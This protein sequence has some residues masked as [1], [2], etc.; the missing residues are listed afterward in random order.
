MTTAV[1]VREEYGYDTYIN[2]VSDPTRPQPSEIGKRLAVEGPHPVRHIVHAHMGELASSPLVPQY[3]FLSE[4]E[5]RAVVD[6]TRQYRRS[7]VYRAMMEL[8]LSN[9]GLGA[10]LYEAVA[11]E[12]QRRLREGLMK[13]EVVLETPASKEASREAVFNRACSGTDWVARRELLY[14][15]VLEG[16]LTRTEYDKARPAYSEIASICASVEHRVAERK[17]P[18]SPSLL[19]SAWHGEMYAL[20]KHAHYVYGVI[21]GEVVADND[22]AL[23]HMCSKLTEPRKD[24]AP[25]RAQFEYLRREYVETYLEEMTDAFK[26]FEMSA[27]IIARAPYIGSDLSGEIAYEEWRGLMRTLDEEE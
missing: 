23:M 6:C 3:E 25:V 16:R 1:L 4:A 10:E 19:Y 12:T 15:L 9:K 24:Y 18:Y 17:G 14:D 5:V 11:S 21:T 26:E 22:L 20:G 8:Q 7:S 13:G 2:L 27:E